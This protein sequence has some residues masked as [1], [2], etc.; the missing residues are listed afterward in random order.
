MA[1][2]VDEARRIVALRGDTYSSYEVLGVLGRSAAEI[3][4]LRSLLKECADDLA[5]EIE[6]RYDR[7]KDHPAML[8][9]YERDMEPVTKARTALASEQKGSQ[10]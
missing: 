9:R 3:E 1:D 10:G 4:R 7:V 8:P 2:I 5:A 6:H